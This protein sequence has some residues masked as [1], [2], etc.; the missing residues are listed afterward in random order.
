MELVVECTYP[1][2]QATSMTLIEF[3]GSLHT[4]AMMAFENIIYSHL[5]EDELALQTCS[6]KD[7][8][9]HEQAK[10]YLPYS[11]FIASWMAISG[12]FY[13]ILFNPEMKRS[14][15]DKTNSKHEIE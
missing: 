14:K 2:N 7:D 8:S 15:A 6:E 5:S 3:S 12:F 4:A 10:N 13:L 1:I 11:I 9:S